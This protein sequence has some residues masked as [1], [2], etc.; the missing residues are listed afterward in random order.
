MRAGCQQVQRVNR[1]MTLGVAFGDSQSVED[2][3]D[4]GTPVSS[5]IED[6]P[7]PGINLRV[8]APNHGAVV[9]AGF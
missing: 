8:G 2:G 6:P 1:V 4:I 9:I 7:R 5:S 3:C